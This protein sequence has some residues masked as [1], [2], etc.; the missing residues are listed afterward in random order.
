VNPK[1]SVVTGGAIPIDLGWIEN[2]GFLRRQQPRWP[3][4]A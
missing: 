2:V 4:I 3:G 1:L